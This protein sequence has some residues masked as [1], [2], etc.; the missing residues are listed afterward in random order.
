MITY[1]SVRGGGVDDVTELPF[2]ASSVPQLQRHR[3]AVHIQHLGLKVHAC[4]TDNYTVLVLV[5]KS[6]PVGQTDLHSLCLKVRS[7]GTDS[8][9][10]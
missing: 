9:T 4:G 3:V 2:L 8:H 1:I 5:R 10:V 6:S 7:S